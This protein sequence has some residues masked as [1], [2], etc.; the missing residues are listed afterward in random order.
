MRNVDGQEDIHNQT[1]TTGVLSN[2][3]I[4]FVKI[5]VKKTLKIQSPKSKFLTALFS[6]WIF[7]F[8][9]FKN[10]IISMRNT[11]NDSPIPM[12]RSAVGLD[13]ST[14]VKE[15]IF[16]LGLDIP[17]LHLSTLGVRCFIQ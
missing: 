3:S 10:K 9:V 11:R 17:T 8:F 15:T 6:S 5:S 4:K 14:S 12:A 7:R 13:R 16:P 1:W 2:I